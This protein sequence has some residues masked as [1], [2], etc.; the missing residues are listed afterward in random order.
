M[1][2]FRTNICLKPLLVAIGLGVV[3]PAA[4][5]AQQDQRSDSQPLEV[6]DSTSALLNSLREINEKTKDWDK[7]LSIIDAG[8]A[9]VKPG[10][11]DAAI[12]YQV[13][14]QTCFQ[15]NDLVNTIAAVDRC[16]AID[17]QHHYF[18]VDTR[19]DMLYLVAQ[20]SF[21]Q[22]TSTKDPKQQ[23]A[24]FSRSD[25]AMEEWMKGTK[26]FSTDNLLFIA[27]LYFYRAQPGGDIPGTEEKMDTALME[28]ALVWTDKG[29]HSMARPRDNLY[30]MKLA[31]L[32]LLKR[33]NEGAEL[34]ELLVKKKPENKNYWQQ[35]ANTYLQ[36]ANDASDLT[37]P[38][39]DD[40]TALD[41]NIRAILTMERAQKLGFMNGP[42]DN[43]NLVV[44]YSTIEQYAESC[45]LLDQGLTNNTI[46]RT[47]KNYELL[48][49]SYQ[50]LNQEFKAID[51]L[52]AATKIF[53]HSGQVEYQ[54]AQIYF[55]INKIKD[56]FEHIKACIAKGG[57]EKPQIA[58]LFYAYLALDL[59]EY[60]EALRGAME[61]KKYPEG[62]EEAQKMEDAIRAT[63]Q[64]RESR[65]QS[66]S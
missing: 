2:L 53:P 65:L 3:L 41:Y 15:K 5:L 48:A 40:R 36:L 63:I 66:Q 43:Y 23:A 13:K 32:F 56:S 38:K 7:A 44:L 24:L 20:I 46:E 4:G 22:A 16:L 34:L 39:H 35:L 58:W 47:R 18:P 62:T 19:R 21:N 52:M 50:L 17:D 42:N 33:F 11:Y 55:T 1:A 6:S 64:E 14:A 51:I 12:L 27:M 26:E 45:R 28:K 37:N 57:T 9:K 25:R 60:D 10:S 8:L 29:L 59:K 61:A 30:Q 31:E 54:I 49:N